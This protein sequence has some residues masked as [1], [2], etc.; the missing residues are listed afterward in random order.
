M[1]TNRPRA[2]KAILASLAVVGETPTGSGTS[3][4]VAHTPR[5][6]TFE[7]FANGLRLTEG[8]D[9][10]GF[11]RDGATITTTESYDPAG[12]GDELRANYDRIEG[13]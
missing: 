2:P 13:T 4:T 7:L 9:A 3:W 11:T 10:G 8:A 6:G 12:E 1:V 5:S